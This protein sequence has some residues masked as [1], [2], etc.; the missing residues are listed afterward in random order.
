[1][2]QSMD[3]PTGELKKTIEVNSMNY[4]DYFRIS[5]SM[6]WIG[7]TLGWIG[8][9]IYFIATF[10]TP[11]CNTTWGFLIADTIVSFILLLFIWRT[12]MLWK[13]FRSIWYNQLI[14]D[15][16]CEIAAMSEG[17]R[18]WCNVAKWLS[19]GTLFLVWMFYLITIVEKSDASDTSKTAPLC[20]SPLD[21]FQIYIIYRFSYISL[22]VLWFIFARRH[23]IECLYDCII[24]CITCKWVPTR[25]ACITCLKSK[26]CPT[27]SECAKYCRTCCRELCCCLGLC[28]DNL[29]ANAIPK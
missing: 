2:Y 29:K 6:F 22:L 15:I 4:S 14:D 13:L 9:N 28:C 27:Q 16:E 10:N 5:A 8:T 19:L 7:A 21:N 23:I 26:W 24:G 17:N 25:N 18:F 11:N 1:M 3:D 12:D 20:N